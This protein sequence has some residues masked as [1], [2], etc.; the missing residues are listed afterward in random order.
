MRLP[1]FVVGLATLMMAGSVRA[2]FASPR[3]QLPPN[4]ITDPR[5]VARTPNAPNF[6]G[7]SFGA[8][9]S[10]SGG[11]QGTVSTAIEQWAAWGI[12]ANGAIPSCTYW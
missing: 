7:Q 9:N 2:A 11:N 8:Q 10:G 5:Q 3:P 12:P 4:C 1:I 6:G